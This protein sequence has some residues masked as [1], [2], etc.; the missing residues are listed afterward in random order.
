MMETPDDIAIKYFDDLYKAL[1]DMT[2]NADE[3][4]P[5]EYR[6]KHFRTAMETAYQ[7]IQRIG[8]DVCDAD[9]ANEEPPSI[10]L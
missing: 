8:M 10:E 6:T 9:R 3:D 7:L 5:S 1:V 4:C 2:V